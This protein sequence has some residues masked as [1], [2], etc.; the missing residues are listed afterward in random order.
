MF[1]WNGTRARQCWIQAGGRGKSGQ[2]LSGASRVPMGRRPRRGVF[3]GLGRPQ[4]LE[5]GG[6]P[7]AAAVGRPRS[8]PRAEWPAR[9]S[10]RRHDR[11]ES[12]WLAPSAT[13]PHTSGA[14]LPGPLAGPQRAGG[15][16]S[17]RPLTHLMLFYHFAEAGVPL[18]DPPVKLGDSHLH[19][20]TIPPRAKPK[21]NARW[22]AAAAVALLMTTHRPPDHRV[23]AVG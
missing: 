13:G 8:Q 5:P 16:E 10:P 22:A 19:F 15:R 14:L 20:N 4:G 21:P 1:S 7:A 23:G 18:R 11:P 6:A 12:P 9:R 2:R 17:R 3:S